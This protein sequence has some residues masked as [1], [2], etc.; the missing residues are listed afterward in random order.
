MPLT[1]STRSRSVLTVGYRNV[2]EIFKNRIK[3]VYYELADLFLKQADQ[4][5]E[6][7]QKQAYFR[8]AR[9][10]IEKMKSAELEDY[11][12]EDC[13]LSFKAK[14]TEI[15]RIVRGTNTAVVYPI[16][17]PDRLELLVSFPNELKRIS[18]NVTDERLTRI[19]EEFRKLLEQRPLHQYLPQAEKLYDWLI[20]PIEADLTAATI[21]TLVFIPGRSS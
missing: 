16:L 4:S 7:S 15:D 2:P 3:P 8:E 1:A 11:F 9:N 12:Q 19:V 10:T 14:Q 18:V 20:R 5:S 6:A 21:D 13:I 17:R